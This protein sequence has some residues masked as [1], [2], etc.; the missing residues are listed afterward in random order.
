MSTPTLDTEEGPLP[1]AL[2]VA[3]AKRCAIGGLPGSQVE[4]DASRIALVFYCAGVLEL[5]GNL[6]PPTTTAPTTPF[7][8]SQLPL[9]PHETEEWRAWVWEQQVHGGGFRAG[10]HA[11]T[12]GEDKNEYDTGHMVMT[13]TALLT[14]A[15]LRDDFANLDREALKGFLGRCQTAEGSF[16]TTPGRRV[17]DGA[18]VIQHGKQGRNP[19]YG[20]P[21]SVPSQDANGALHDFIGETDLRTVYCAFAVCAMLNDWSGLDVAG[22]VGFVRRCR[23]YEGGYAQTPGGEAHGGLTYVA[24]AAL[25][26]AG[27]SGSS[28]EGLSSNGWGLTVRERT[29]TVRFL[30]SLQDGPSG[31]FA[32]RTG[33]EADACYA[34]W[35]VGALGV[36]DA[37]TGKGQSSMTDSLVDV[38][39]LRTFLRACAF[40]YGGLGKAPGERPDPY[41]TYLGLASDAITRGVLDPVLNATG[42]T[43]AWARA[44]VSGKR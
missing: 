32:G 39:A 35:V 44:W 15:A 43:A 17:P 37:S 28:P 3:H 36:L 6:S 38:A 9:R 1:R 34:F 11:R 12:R 22:A 33:K 18:R 27:E 31:G 13:Y 7:D 5:V 20:G 4:A 14:L 21:W 25:R 30:V 40:K 23:T 41:H 26:L 24:L 29:A 16:S 10:P 8:A 42:P 2:D 19:T